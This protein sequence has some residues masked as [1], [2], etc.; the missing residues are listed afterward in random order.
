MFKNWKL[1]IVAASLLVGGTAL[2]DHKQDGKRDGTDRRAK[3]M[4]KFD[5]NGDGKLDQAERA[6]MQKA[7]FDRLDKNHDGVLSFDEAQH[8]LDRG[9]FHNRGGKMG[10]RG[11]DRDGRRGG[12][13]QPE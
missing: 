5:T 10:K 1:A 12:A 13:D 3:R 7:K 11:G 6:A 8:M 2:A 9:S 4:A